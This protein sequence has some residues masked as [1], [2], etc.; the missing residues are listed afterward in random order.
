MIL[1]R[2]LNFLTL[3]PVTCTPNQITC[4]DG[5][6]VDIRLRCDGRRDCSD[7]LDEEGCRKYS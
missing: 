4:R 1:Y 5:S 2:K 6:C 7:G 3:L